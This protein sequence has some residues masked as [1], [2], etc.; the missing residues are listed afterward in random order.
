M[1]V[2]QPKTKTVARRQ[3]SADASA[4]IRQAANGYIVESYP[5][6]CL[7]GEPRRLVGKHGMWIVPIVLTSPGYGAVG[8][9]GMVAVAARSHEVVGATPRGEV[10]AAIKKLKEAHSDALEAAFDQART[11]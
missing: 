10:T 2:R 7:G 1:Q 8:D 9:V 4:T 11:V 5:F 6:G 3:S